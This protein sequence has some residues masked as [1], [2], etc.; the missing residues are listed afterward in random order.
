MQ[1]RPFSRSANDMAARRTYE[2]LDEPAGEDYIALLRAASG[3]CATG[4]LTIPPALT[5]T[6]LAVAE[7]L[8]TA[9]DAAAAPVSAGPLVRFPI[10]PGTLDVLADNA[11]TLYSWRTPALPDSLCLFRPDGSPWLISVAS[12]RLGYIELTVLERVRLSHVAPTVASSLANRAARDAVLASLERRLE[13][14]TEDL[15]DEMSAYARDSAAANRDVL[16]DGMLAWLTSGDDVRA[17]V[18]TVLSGRLGLNEMREALE[19]YLDWLR[20][21]DSS[22]HVFS[23]NTVLRDRWIA[24]RITAVRDALAQLAR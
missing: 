1:H 2:I 11:T 6:G 4:A 10:T 3:E 22:S 21:G 15:V 8:R 12:Q 7:A 14:R 5:D 24:R 16:V 17:A 20:S 18:A 9:A 23:D 13:E 19:E